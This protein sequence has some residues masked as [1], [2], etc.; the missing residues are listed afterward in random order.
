M[1]TRSTLHAIEK[2]EGWCSAE[3][4]R[5]MMELVGRVAPAICVE[6]GVFGGRSLVAMGDACRQVGRGHVY[7]IDPWT[8]TAAL[9]TVA[10]EANRKWWADLDYEETYLGCMAGIGR[11]GL[12]PWITVLRTTS[13]RAAR[14]F[15]AIDILHI[16]GNHS[17]DVSTRD[18]DTY[19]PLVRPGGHVWFDDMDWPTTRNAQTVL[20]SQCDEV[21]VV[22]NCGLFQKRA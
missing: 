4:A 13:A 7:G 1:N 18:V 16:D 22:G 15:S 14:L 3:K 5:A 19:L 20:L 8:A 9:E 12:D 11:L 21:D 10:E 6:I 17:E 2:L